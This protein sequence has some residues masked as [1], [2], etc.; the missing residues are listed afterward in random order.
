MTARRTTI[1]LLME[2][3]CPAEAF[4][5]PH[6]TCEQGS[7]L[8]ALNDTYQRLC[9]A[10][11]ML[12]A[13]ARGL[14]SVGQ[15]QA[16]APNPMTGVYRDHDDRTRV[17]LDQG[18][19]TSL[20]LHE[21]RTAINVSTFSSCLPRSANFDAAVSSRARAPTTRCSDTQFDRPTQHR[22][23]NT[24]HAPLVK[25]PRSAGTRPRASAA[26]VNPRR[27]STQRQ[28]VSGPPSRPPR[29]TR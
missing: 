2:D 3:F 5:V 16:N 17:Y 11:Y 24:D 18:A 21:S 6:S 23:T 12:F 28:D 27:M 8:R 4:V 25:E 9:R 19:S 22:A 14:R 7:S 20:H 15:R 26:R 1:A 10:H 13:S 29:V